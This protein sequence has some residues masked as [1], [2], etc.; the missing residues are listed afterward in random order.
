M[1]IPEIAETQSFGKRLLF[2]TPKP[3][4]SFSGTERKVRGF[5]SFKGYLCREIKSHQ[6]VCPC[7]PIFAELEIYMSDVQKPKI[8]Y[9]CGFKLVRQSQNTT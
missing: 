9:M 6:M 3:K 2:K 7:R 5:H 4:P 1:C 8:I